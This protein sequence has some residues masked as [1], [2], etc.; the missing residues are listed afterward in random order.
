MT[1]ISILMR[2]HAGPTGD[3]LV[4]QRPDG[5]WEL[6]RGYVHVNEAPEAAVTRTVWETLGVQAKAGQL[7]VQGRKY[8]KDGTVEH[9]PC[10]NIT[11]NTHT[12]C[13]EH[14]YYEAVNLYQAEPKQGAYQGFRWV[15]PSE[16]EQV[17]L[18]GDDKAFLDK[19]Q[20]WVNGQTIPDVRMY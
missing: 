12:K 20:P 6:P 8:P 13:N 11:H 16:L 4:C 7:M 2:H 14:W 5:G 9:I 15:H 1:E 10:G 18:T 17:E 19:Y 3:V